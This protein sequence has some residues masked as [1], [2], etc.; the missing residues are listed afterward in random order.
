[1]EFSLSFQQAPQSDYSHLVM[2][3]KLEDLLPADINS[4]G[5]EFLC[6]QPF[7]QYNS[8]SLSKELSVDG[9]PWI[10]AVAYPQLLL[11]LREVAELMYKDPAS[12][13]SYRLLVRGRLAFFHNMIL[14]RPAKTLADITIGSYEA[15]FAAY[16]LQQN[17]AQAHF[18]AVKLEFSNVLLFYYKYT[19]SERCMEVCKQILNVEIEYT[20]RL[21]RRTKFQ[22]FDTAQLV[23]KLEEYNGKKK[24]QELSDVDLEI[25]RK[26]REE[27]PPMESVLVLEDRKPGDTVLKAVQLDEESIL[28]EIPKF[29]EESVDPNIR[30]L[31][32]QLLV[33]T[34][35]YY[36]YESSPKEETLFLKLNS[37]VASLL[38]SDPVYS[39][40]FALLVLR[41]LN[42]LPRYKNSDRA[43]EQLQQLI[44][45]YNSVEKKPEDLVLIMSTPLSYHIRVLLLK[46][47]A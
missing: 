25:I 23:V 3:L 34:H 40:K 19:E 20:G 5:F 7:V 41:S 38:A 9:E 16:R 8:R 30:G 42:E 37:L 11:A 45:Q 32:K 10:E 21:G 47:V 35:S 14:D 6:S 44:D 31:E 46:L 29:T 33:L 27:L 43:L 36:M 15:Y 39:L 2:D 18:V 26:E 12:T 22:Q 17:V 28:F 4:Y 13:D 1:M 24:T